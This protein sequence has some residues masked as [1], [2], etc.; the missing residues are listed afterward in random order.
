MTLEQIQPW[1]TR[2]QLAYAQHSGVIEREPNLPRLGSPHL[3]RW[4]EDVTYHSLLTIQHKILFQRLSGFDNKQQ[5]NDFCW[6]KKGIPHS[7]QLQIQ[8]SQ[9][10]EKNNTSQMRLRSVFKMFIRI[11]NT[12]ITEQMGCIIF[13]FFR[14]LLNLQIRILVIYM[15]DLEISKILYLENPSGLST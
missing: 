5:I 14:L 4:G 10:K 6:K 15:S 13:F 2:G 9:K 3:Y 12:A 7:H 1:D 11:L 8:N